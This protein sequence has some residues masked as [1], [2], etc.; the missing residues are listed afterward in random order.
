V[1][2]ATTALVGA[3]AKNLKEFGLGVPRIESVERNNTLTELAEYQSK[4]YMIA[5]NYGC[6]SGSCFKIIKE[7]LK[8][9]IKLE[10]TIFIETTGTNF[11]QKYWE[12]FTNVYKVSWVY[13]LVRAEDLKNRNKRR[14]R[15]HFDEWYH[16]GFQGT[17]FRLPDKDFVE[18]SEVIQKTF[19]TVLQQK[20]FDKVILISNQNNSKPKIEG[21]FHV[22]DRNNNMNKIQQIVL[23]ENSR[24]IDVEN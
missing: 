13:V 10:K 3:L 7:K 6:D 11:T 16:S 24:K 15:A 2:T 18:A 20:N 12:T 5:R 4:I 21:A 14:A 23:K 19:Q 22:N 9:A 8:D 17:P 1:S